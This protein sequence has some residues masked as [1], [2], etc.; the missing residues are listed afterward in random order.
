LVSDSFDLR[1]VLCDDS[2]VEGDE[3]VTFTATLPAGV[4]LASGSSNP[5]TGTILDDDAAANSVSLSVSSATVAEGSSVTVTATVTEAPGAGNSFV[6]PI[7]VASGSATTASASDYTFAATSITI[8]GT[9]TTGTATFTADDDLLDE[10]DETVRVQLGT[11]PTGLVA[12]SPSHVDITITDTDV[13]VISVTAGTSPVTE[14]M[15]ASFTITASPAPHTALT[16]NLTVAQQGMFVADAN[17]GTKQITVPTSGSATHTVNTVPDSLDEVDGSVTV[18]AAAG[19]GYTP[20]STAASGTVAVSDDDATTA[21]FAAATYTAGEASGDRSVNAVVELSLAAPVGGRVV[22]YAVSGTA[23]PGTDFATLSGSVTVAAGH[24]TANI[25]VTVT[26]DSADEPAETVRLTITAATGYLVGGDAETVISI[27]DDDPT[28]VTLA[29]TSTSVTKLT[30]GG[31]PSEVTFRVSLGRALVHGER[32]DVPLVLSGDNVTVDDLDD[33]ALDTDSTTR[34][35]SGVSLDDEETLT[36][37]VIFTGAA[38]PQHAYLKLAITDDSLVEDNETLKISLADDSTFDADTDTDVDGGADPHMTMDTPPVPDNFD[39]TLESDDMGNA[40]SLSVSSASVAEGSSVTITATLATAPGSGN[41]FTIPVVVASGSATT[42]SASDYTFTATS[43]TVSGTSTTGTATF[44]ADDD[45]L[46]EPD[47]T[48]RVQLGTLPSSLVAGSPSH[49]DITITDTDVPVV[50]VMPGSAVTEGTAA[51]FTVTASPAPHTALTVN[52]TV[53]Q[54][55][56]F[57]AAGDIGTDTVSVPTTGSA[58]YMV[59]TVGDSIDEADGSVTVTATAG[60]GYTL[61]ST[62]ASGT[63]AVSDDDATTAQFAAAMYTVGEASGSRTVNVVV[64]LSLPA[65]VGGRTVTYTVGTE[66]T[67]ATPGTGNDYNTLSGSVTV[68]AGATTANIPIT[69]LDDNVEDPAETI[70]LTITAGTGYAV[71]AQAST[72]VTIVD[73]DAPVVELGFSVSSGNVN[74]GDHAILEVNVTSGSVPVAGLEIPFTINAGAAQAGDASSADYST[75]DADHPFDS[76]MSGDALFGCQKPSGGV[77]SLAAGD[78]SGRVCVKTVDDTADETRERIRFGIGTLPS[79]TALSGGSTV[80]SLRL[81]ATVIDADPTV[82]TVTGGGAITEGDTSSSTTV[83]VSLARALGMHPAFVTSSQRAE[84]AAIHLDLATLTGAALPGAT[85]P[86]FTIAVQTSGTDSGVTLAGATSEHPTLTF[87]ASSTDTPQTAVLV[88]TAT[89]RDDGDTADETVTLDLSRLPDEIS[90]LDGGVTAHADDH[91]A[92]ITIVDDDKTYD[93]ELHVWYRLF[94]KWAYP[95]D[96]L[97]PY[98]YSNPPPLHRD[99]WHFLRDLWLA[100]AAGSSPYNA[101]EYQ[102]YATEPTY[103]DATVTAT[104]ADPNKVKLSLAPGGTPANSVTFTISA[105]NGP[106]HNG[107]LRGDTA[108]GPYHGGDHGCTVPVWVHR[109]TSSSQP[110]ECVDITHT[111]SGSDLTSLAKIQVALPRTDTWAHIQNSRA[112]YPCTRVTPTTGRP[113]PQGGWAWEQ[114]PAVEGQPIGINSEMFFVDPGWDPDC[115]DATRAIGILSLDAVTHDS[116]SFSWSALNCPGGY[117]VRWWQTGDKAGTFTEAAVDRSTSRHTAG[118]LAPGTGYTIRVLY[119]D[120]D[121]GR[122]WKATPPL[123]ATTLTP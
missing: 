17:L 67:A 40:V 71:G 92:A 8:S 9:A 62:A 58:T 80:D 34:P 2:D 16:V 26:D 57:V 93:G 21:Q 38:G 75:A 61:S 95:D 4:A 103:E 12:G 25:P 32:I 47:E 36:P 76:L 50:S 96:L 123:T 106:C 121:G 45:L 101:L 43:I 31:S 28:L 99:N 20:H 105:G 77:I 14:G 110:D 33:L 115:G 65:P 72:T 23:T 111:V 27:T 81:N 35:N 119:Q 98:N 83:T 49:V 69:V 108:G 10:A 53:A 29:K 102:I 13:P 46:D 44:T 60:T 66:S 91:T 118:G 64:E 112:T 22:T 39:V 30:E 94:P 41:T 97:R 56:M 19:S 55:G 52:L 79:G 109:L 90:G 116:I 7:M 82:V 120:P 3:T 86:D 73:D 104:S 42:A 48:V 74:E 88:I 5:A 18:T 37:T 78:T 68:A 70:I 122:P 1:L 6:I 24:T 89:S 51:S 63:V 85:N 54:S 100:A 84:T 87:T 114:G 15:P 11:P 59:D 107:A 113:D 117:A